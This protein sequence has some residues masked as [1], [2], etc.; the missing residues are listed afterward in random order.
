MEIGRL[1]EREVEGFWWCGLEREMKGLKTSI[2]V[3]W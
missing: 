2:I 1:G 3:A